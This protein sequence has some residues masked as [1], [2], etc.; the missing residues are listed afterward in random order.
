MHWFRMEF[1][2]LSIPLLLLWCWQTRF[3][4][5][6]K[7]WQHVGDANLIKSLLN[8]G[9]DSQQRLINFGLLFAWSLAVIALMGPSISQIAVPIAR[10]HPTQV[11]LFDLSRNILQTD[12]TPNRLTRA[13][14]KLN[15]LLSNT[16]EAAT[17]LIAFSKEAFIASPITQDNA[18]INTL[19]TDLHPAIMPVSGFD[20]SDAL[21]RANDLLTQAN[22]NQAVIQIFLSAAPDEI[23]VAKAKQ[24]AQ[25]GYT[26][27]TYVL[28]TDAQIVQ[29]AQALSEAGNGVMVQFTHDDQD[30][31]QLANS[32]N[33]ENTAQALETSTYRAWRD[34]GYWLLWPLAI[35]VLFSFRRGWVERLYV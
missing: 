30:I 25:A 16:S 32:L 4:M 28:S 15:D 21:T 34:Q 2:I 17:G 22:Y 14:Y 6:K 8:P 12:L 18:T 26:I 20:V 31:L 27:N 9:R 24:L 5:D 7:V 35:L 29:K 3:R 33:L 23:A 10:Y 11:I 1:L 13:K 19:I